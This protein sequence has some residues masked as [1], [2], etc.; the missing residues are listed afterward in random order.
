M[1][2]DSKVEK[3]CSRRYILKAFSRISTSDIIPN[4]FS[5]TMNLYPSKKSKILS[6]NQITFKDP[7]SPDSCRMGNERKRSLSLSAF[8]KATNL[9][10]RA[11]ARQKQPGGWQASRHPSSLPVRLWPKRLLAFIEILELP[12]IMNFF[13]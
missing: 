2:Y 9:R 7:Q 5:H 3:Y 6:E 12:L 8:P 10:Q 11:F 4:S 1:A 13:K